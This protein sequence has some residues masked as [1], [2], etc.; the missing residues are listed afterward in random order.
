MVALIASE[1]SSAS[2]E[3]PSLSAF[4]IIVIAGFVAGFVN[5]LA[6]G[7]SLLTVPALVFA[8]LPIDVANGTNRV[9]VALQSLVGAA[10]FQRKG[11]GSWRL[12]AQALVPMVPGA[13]LGALMGAYWLEPQYLEWVLFGS[14]FA[15]AIGMLIQSLRR[16][17]ATPAIPTNEPELDSP[18]QHAPVDEDVTP[19][20]HGRRRRS[21]SEMLGLFGAGLY[22]GLVQAGI[23]LVLIAVFTGLM[24]TTL[25]QANALKLSCVLL[26][27]LPILLIFAAAGQVDWLLGLTLSASTIVGTLLGVRVA[28]RASTRSIRVVVALSAAA[29]CIGALVKQ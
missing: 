8:G 23:G 25:L 14:M 15:V 21:W 16:Q 28:L 13:I 19:F 11:V 1:Q 3:L 6:G 4:A 18:L 9:G 20:P 10:Q 29:A 26:Y 27:T 12:T 24:R 5:T 7:G 2:L 22:G 17:P